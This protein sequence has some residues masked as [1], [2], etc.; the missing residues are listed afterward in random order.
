MSAV[1]LTGHADEGSHASG[2]F[3]AIAKAGR[4]ALYRMQL[5]RMVSVLSQYDDATL[6][7]I[8]ITRSEIWEY[9]DSLVR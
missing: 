1:E 6:R 8:G 9:A 4:K 3:A 5:A 2:V 7:S